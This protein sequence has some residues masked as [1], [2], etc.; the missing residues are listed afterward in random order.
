[1]RGLFKSLEGMTKANADPV[2]T[3]LLNEYRNWQ[4]IVWRF[5]K[6]LL[7]HKVSKTVCEEWL[8]NIKRY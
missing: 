8:K 3:N 1:M 2:E 7:E 6:W 4:M 5:D